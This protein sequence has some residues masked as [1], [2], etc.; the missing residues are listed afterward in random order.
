MATCEII[1]DKWLLNPVKGCLAK[2]KECDWRKPPD[3]LV[4]GEIY[5]FASYT[6]FSPGACEALWERKPV[7]IIWDSQNKRIDSVHPV[8][9]DQKT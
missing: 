9:T 4:T 2:V 1:L 6:R 7:K 3:R 5:P 8:V